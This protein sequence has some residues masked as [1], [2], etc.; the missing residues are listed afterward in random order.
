MVNLE[1]INII[2]Y[3]SF[4]RHPTEYIGIFDLSIKLQEKNDAGVKRTATNY[5]YRFCFSEPK[6]FKM[7][8]VEV[9]QNMKLH[10]LNI[11]SA[12]DH[13]NIYYT[14]IFLLLFFHNWYRSTI[15]SKQSCVAYT[16]R[17]VEQDVHN[18]ST[19]THRYVLLTE[20]L[21]GAFIIFVPLKSFQ[22]IR[23]LK[24]KHKT[25]SLSSGR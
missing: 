4:K 5:K 6:I 23:K 17:L 10:S 25:T 16:K 2:S 24:R 19:E 18:S 15:R 9:S 8:K 21:G 7:K 22:E 3:N 1:I 11:R 14:I 20:R 13:I 12:E